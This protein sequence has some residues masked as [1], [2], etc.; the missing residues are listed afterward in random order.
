MA[1]NPFQNTHTAG[2]YG[3]RAWRVP[4]FIANNLLL[5]M[6]TCWTLVFFTGFFL[7]RI[8]FNFYNH[9]LWSNLQSLSNKRK[10]K[11]RIPGENI[12][13]LVRIWCFKVQIGDLSLMGE[14]LITSTPKTMTKAF[15]IL[16]Q[17]KKKTQ[18][19]LLSH[20]W[21]G[22]TG[23]RFFP[24]V[25]CSAENQVSEHTAKCDE[26]QTARTLEM[27][28]SAE[29]GGEARYPTVGS[30]GSLPACCS[31]AW[32]RFSPLSR[33]LANSSSHVV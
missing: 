11:W 25:I 5:I 12:N 10:K 33:L 31:L 23:C 27:V 7:Y 4:N 1:C 8:F 32:L 16:Q 18:L 28:T 30:V 26:V 29:A 3:S 21:R 20:P 15:N 2:H 14:A 17:I 19:S 22:E 6:N 13:I 9:W 24:S